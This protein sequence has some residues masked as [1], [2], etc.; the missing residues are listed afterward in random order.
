MAA[1]THILVLDGATAIAIALCL[2]KGAELLLTQDQEKIF[3]AKLEFLTLWLSYSNPLRYYRRVINRS[4]LSIA[5]L[6]I[7]IAGF[8]LYRTFVLR[9]WTLREDR[10]ALASIGALA[11][12]LWSIKFLSQY[13]GLMI[14]VTAGER[15]KEQDLPFGLRQ[16]LVGYD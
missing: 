4:L 13:S 9:L 14:A 16:F 12:F 1:H 15:E 11:V 10:Y 6:V 5:A 8:P 3:K 2:T 7:S